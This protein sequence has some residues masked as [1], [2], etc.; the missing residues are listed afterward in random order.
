MNSSLCNIS[1]LSFNSA[2]EWEIFS[3][4][5]S[6]MLD[7]IW[8]W[9]ET[10][11]NSEGLI[12]FPGICEICN[13][14]TVFS[15]NPIYAPRESEYFS[16]KYKVNWWALTQCGCKLSNLERAALSIFKEGYE[17][18]EDIYHVGHFSL[19]R[20]WL[21]DKFPNVVSSQFFLGKF[22]GEDV[23]GVRNEDVSRLS[24]DDASFNSLIC[25]EILEHV[26]DYRVA[27]LE[28]NRVLKQDGRA[29]LSFP[30]LGGNTYDNLTRAEMMEDGQTIKYLMEPEYHGDP[31]DAQGILSFRSFGW[32]ILDDLRSAGFKKASA[33]FI[34]SPIH[35]YMTLLNPIIVGIK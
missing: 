4:D 23:G 9:H 14:N 26:P 16:F 3:R 8:L 6:Q 33:E 27:L 35:G 34:F 22:P 25:M 5:N 30:W 18:N 29:I 31:A 12:K 10:L 2:D 7:K 32:Q 15:A 11:G 1:R 17:L 28:M 19:F 20:N 21:S 24:F 13:I